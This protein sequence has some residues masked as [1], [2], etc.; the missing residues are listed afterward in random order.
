MSIAFE[1][2]KSA[3]ITSGGRNKMV[4]KILMTENGKWKTVFVPEVVDIFK[5]IL[6]D[7]EYTLNYDGTCNI[8]GWKGTKNGVASTE[9]VVPYHQK[10]IF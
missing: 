3:Y 6:Q 1:N 7:F 2:V 4:K 10:I 9:M 5:E 8:T